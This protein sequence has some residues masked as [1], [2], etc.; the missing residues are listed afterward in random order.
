[1]PNIILLASEHVAALPVSRALGRAACA[2]G[3][4]EGPFLN[5][6]LSPNEDSVLIALRGEQLLAGVAD[7]HFGHQA[8]ERLVRN[9]LEQVEHAWP[10]DSASLREAVLRADEQGTESVRDRSES[11][12]LVTLVAGNAVHWVNIADSVLYLVTAS[13]IRELNTPSSVFGGGTVS[14]RTRQQ[15]PAAAGVELADHG[16]IACGGGDVLL[17][18]SD[19]IL[20]ESSGI[21]MAEVGAATRRQG[22]LEER[23]AALAL[24]ACSRGQGGGR[25]NV[26]IVAVEFA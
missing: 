8:G 10:S 15:R 16:T 9:L 24:R 13:G 14:L 26:G 18:C 17:L 23:T 12:F 5:P 20:E 6:K 11:T 4:G 22:T 3:K 7:S 21:P 25:D 1:M 19:G 2:L